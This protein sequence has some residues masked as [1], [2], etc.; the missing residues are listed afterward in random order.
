RR[1][2]RPP[3]D[4]RRARGPA[5][6]A[7]AAPPPAPAARIRGRVRLTRTG[8]AT[9]PARGAEWVHGSGGTVSASIRHRWTRV[10]ERPTPSAPHRRSDGAPAPVL[11][12]YGPRVHR[13]RP[14]CLGR[15]DA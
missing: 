12:R 7:A 6:V 2:P 14:P 4:R 15:G 1:S 8:E 9:P 3:E 5:G 13:A 11:R 10:R